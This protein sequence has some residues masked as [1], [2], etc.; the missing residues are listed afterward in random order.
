MI[1]YL[2]ELKL[3]LS[4]SVGIGY[5]RSSKDFPDVHALIMHA[6]NSDNADLR[7]D[8]LGLHKALCVIMGWNY[9]RPP[10]I[11]KAYQRLPPEE[12]A[13]NQDD[14]IMWPPL[15]IINNTN[16]GKSKEG[17]IE[18]LGNKAMDSKLRGIHAFF[19]Y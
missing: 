6:Y 1:N 7:V 11:S 14:L 8:H 19:A 3:S 18:G 16:T 13:T 15:V 5:Y 9:L 4:D 10:D 17:R 12:V 2:S